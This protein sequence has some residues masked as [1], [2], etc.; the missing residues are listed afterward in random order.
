MEKGRLQAVVLGPRYERL[1]PGLSLSLGEK[2]S[3]PG[4]WRVPRWQGPLCH[5]RRRD[6]TGVRSAMNTSTVCVDASFVLRMFLGPD[7][8]EAWKR[9]EASLAEGSGFRAPSLFGYEVANALHRYQRAG[10]LSA[11]T[12][13]IVLD[14]VLALPIALEPEA[15]LH[16]A[17]LR[18]AGVLSLSATYDAHYLALA[19]R[20]ARSWT[21]DAELERRLEGRGPRVRLLG[22]MPGRKAT[23]HRPCVQYRARPG[24]D[25][26]S[27]SRDHLSDS[28]SYAAWR[29]ASSRGSGCKSRPHHARRMV[30][31]VFPFGVEN[32]PIRLDHQTAGGV[33]P[34][35]EGSEVPVIAGEQMGGV[36]PSA[37]SSISD[38]S[39]AVAIAGNGVP[40]GTPAA[41]AGWPRGERYEGRGEPVESLGCFA[42]RL[43]CGLLDR[44]LAEAR[45]P[46]PLCGHS[47]TNAACRRGCGRR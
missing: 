14:A 23:D 11:V 26:L 5:V 1:L 29:A 45:C 28:G 2:R 18:L 34:I 46:Q 38:P 36:A 16:I 17:A 10:H 3:A 44:V 12:A 37:A 20:L 19:E 24:C 30:L 32:R 6:P 9:W 13:E 43:R 4:S 25:L 35:H 22:R 40:A 39:A 21:A 27:A 33:R 31:R 41:G 42:A 8:V 15:S 7:D 47:T